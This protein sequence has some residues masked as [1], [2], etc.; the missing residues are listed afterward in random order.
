VPIPSSEHKLL[1]CAAN[2]AFEEIRLNLFDVLAV[3]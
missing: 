3:W 2:A 1:I